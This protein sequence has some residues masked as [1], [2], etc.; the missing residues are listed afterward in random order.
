[1]DLIEERYFHRTVVQ[2]SEPPSNRRWPEDR[3]LISVNFLKVKAI[4]HDNTM[5][6]S[7]EQFTHIGEKSYAILLS[8][9]KKPRFENYY[10]QMFYEAL[11]GLGV[12]HVE[13]VKAVKELFGVIAA[14]VS[15]NDIILCVYDLTLISPIG[16]YVPRPEVP[17]KLIPASKS[18]IQGLEPVTLDDVITHT[19]ECPI[20]LED[21]AAFVKPITALPCTHHYH[22]H[23]IVR[24]MENSHLCPICRYPMPIPVLE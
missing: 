15:T 7:Y 12:P 3:V 23:C 1:M 18:S 17:P 14:A 11:T 13:Q 19:P 9:F 16:G 2:E 4:R 20:C 22:V 10:A 24:W 8:S 21:F 5:P 6:Y